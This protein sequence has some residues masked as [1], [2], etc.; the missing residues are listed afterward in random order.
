MYKHAPGRGPIKA[1][2][3]R[4]NELGRLRLKDAPTIGRGSCLEILTMGKV[5]VR[6]SLPHCPISRRDPV[7]NVLLP[8]TVTSGR[9]R[10]LQDAPRSMVS[11]LAV[12]R[13]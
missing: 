5:M 7:S 6:P 8:E 9:S 4:K 13:L 11:P 2:V 12:L 1:T 10:C 3:D